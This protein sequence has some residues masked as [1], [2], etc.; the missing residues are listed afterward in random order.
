VQ[1][2]IGIVAAL[3][4]LIAGAPAQ[5]AEPINASGQ[6]SLKL[7]DGLVW[8]EVHVSGRAEPLHFVLDTGAG[9]SV[10]NAETAREL[11]LKPGRT[12]TVQ[13]TQGTAP[14]RWVSGLE[15]QVAGASLPG[16][17]LS[18]DLKNVSQQ[19]HQ[20]IDGLLGADFLAGRKVQLDFAAG[21]LRVDASYQALPAD[22]V[23]LPMEKRNDAWC[24]AAQVNQGQRG[25]Y[26]ID[27]GF[28]GHLSWCPTSPSGHA[29]PTASTVALNVGSAGNVTTELRI[30]SMNLPAVATTVLERPL[31]ARESGLL[32]LGVLRRYC[33][34]FEAD[35]KVVHLES[36]GD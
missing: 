1:F 35:R 26:R 23:T 28:D 24:V 4:C 8:L 32:G 11:G 10:I 6:T 27:T 16:K 25:W 9:V 3:F 34:T 13:G 5:A 22:A 36:T 15:A 7:S 2:R 21:V 18:L 29:K 20:R 19:C 31:F 14:A 33:V 30:G 12:L 17:L